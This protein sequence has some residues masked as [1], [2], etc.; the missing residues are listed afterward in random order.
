MDL[1]LQTL[2]QITS[3]LKYTYEY[4]I[5]CYTKYV[6]NNTI[7]IITSIV[8]KTVEEYSRVQMERIIA[9]IIRYGRRW[10]EE[11]RQHRRRRRMTAERIAR[12]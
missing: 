3:F 8:L 4:K 9:N 11:G 2:S 5:N 6:E 10:S 12:I 1:N 7:G